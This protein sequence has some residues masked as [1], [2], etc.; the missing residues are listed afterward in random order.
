MDK[1]KQMGIPVAGGSSLLVIFAVLCLVVFAL[2]CLTT[3]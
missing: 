3:A 1:R 2:L